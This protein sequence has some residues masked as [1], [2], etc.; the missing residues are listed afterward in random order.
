M[1]SL[2]DQCAFAHFLPKPSKIKAFT[3]DLTAAKLRHE[4][5]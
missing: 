1:A 2:I 4:G 3:K 5:C